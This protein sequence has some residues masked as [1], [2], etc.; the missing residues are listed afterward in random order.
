MDRAVFPLTV[1]VDNKIQFLGTAFYIQEFGGF[2]TA[3]HNLDYKDV[4]LKDKII[5]ITKVG[6]NK[7]L[8]RRISS[9]NF[10]PTADI[11]VGL[12]EDKYFESDLK[13]IANYYTILDF[14]DVPDG[15]KIRTFAYPK[16]TV[17]FEREEYWGHFIPEVY[18]G[19]VIETVVRND[20]FL[21]GKVYH[22]NMLIRSGSSGGPVFNKEGNVIG[23]NSTGFDLG[24]GED[25]ISFITPIA[26]ALDVQVDNKTT[27]RELCKRGYGNMKFLNFSEEEE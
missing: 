11:S 27:L 22:S 1:F 6:K 18:N 4:N 12:L 2:I 17:E 10:H 25:P 13:V 16:S 26:Y 5:A 14:D 15:S 19:K 7:Y 9:I 24:N 21:K 8:P 23:V 20:I 3:K